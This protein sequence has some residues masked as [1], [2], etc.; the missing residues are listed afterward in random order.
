MQ[1]WLEFLKCSV[2]RLWRDGFRTVALPRRRHVNCILRSVLFLLIFCPAVPAQQ[3]PQS[4]PAG[5]KYP[6]TDPPIP[7]KEILQLRNKRDEKTPTTPIWEQIDD[8]LDRVPKPSIR[9]EGQVPRSDPATPAP[10]RKEGVDTKSHGLPTESSDLKNAAIGSDRHDGD[11]SVS[12]QDLN[13][14]VQQRDRLDVTVQTVNDDAIK[15]FSSTSTVLLT[16]IRNNRISVTPETL[17]VLEA[18]YSYITSLAEGVDQ[19]GDYVVPLT[20]ED[21]FRLTALRATSAYRK[22]KVDAAKGGVGALDDPLTET[23]SVSVEKDGRPERYLAVERFSPY[24]D[25]KGKPLPIERIGLSTPAEARMPIVHGCYYA[26]DAEGRTVTEIVTHH[27]RHDGPFNIAI[28]VVGREHVENN[29]H[30]VCRR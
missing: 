29:R 20:A 25:R 1:L 14:L 7:P 4:L 26:K 6:I 28:R 3:V 15:Q 18:E 19:T 17:N 8:Q 5:P 2:V 13:T 10:F 27:P 23:V 9:L 11:T 22:R 12:R 30:E 16:A 24:K 21:L